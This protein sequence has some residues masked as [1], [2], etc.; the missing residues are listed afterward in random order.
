[1][2]LWKKIL[3]GMALGIIVGIFMGGLGDYLRPIGTVF[4]RAIQMVIVPLV[5][6]SLITA[7]ASARDP[8]SIG[9]LGG[10]A[11]AFYLV[12]TAISVVAGLFLGHLATVEQGVPV[13]DLIAAGGDL[14]LP[15]VDTSL[16]S[17]LI[18]LIPPN[19][20][21]ALAS[22]QII[23]IIVFALGIGFAMNLVGKAAKPLVDIFE[24]GAE[25]MYKLTSLIMSLA[26][27]AVFALM[28][29]LVGS[30]GLQSLMAML[31]FIVLAY[32][33]YLFILLLY[34][35]VVSFVTKSPLGLFY[36]NIS[37]PLLLAFSTSS[38]S[39]ALPVSMQCAQQTMGVSKNVS[40][41]LLPLGTTV[42][43]SGTALY[44]G[45]SVSFLAHIFNMPL[46][47]GDYLLVITTAI[48]GAIGT[49]G[50]PGAGLV[51]LS[52][53]L[54]AVGLPLEGVLIMAAIDRIL[55]MGRSAMN[56]TG[57]L[58]ATVL[59]GKSED[60]FEEA[61]YRAGR[62]KAEVISQS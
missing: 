28:V 57:D 55:D 47:S 2:A 38:S 54:V 48:L 20:I 30:L 45:A 6:C 43:M 60:E 27:Y 62:Q 3:I 35:L 17:I 1:M 52:V 19:P 4:I 14:S 24:A 25:V 39:A 15:E 34:G 53:S 21:A 9:R 37:A 61:V 16:T 40:N 12:F 26:P 58:A 51:M 11:C 44:I 22:G 56:V 41:F 29:W 32:V 50:V 42:N 49:A 59:I 33:G 7:F 31:K 46:S 5:F 36:K 8:G 23:Q 10:K 18:N 13:S